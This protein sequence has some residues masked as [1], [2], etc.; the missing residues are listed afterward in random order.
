MKINFL[1]EGFHKPLLKKIFQ[2]VYAHPKC[3]KCKH[4]EWNVDCRAHMVP[5]GKGKNKG[6]V[7]QLRTSLIILCAKCKMG[8]KEDIG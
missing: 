2:H 6:I 7:H 5:P 1:F 4:E 3:K 8:K